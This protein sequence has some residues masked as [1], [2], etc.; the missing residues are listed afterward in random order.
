[1]HYSYLKDVSKMAFIYKSF[2]FNT[3]KNMIYLGK[4]MI[5]LGVYSV[6]LKK[7]L[8]LFLGKIYP[9]TE[10]KF[11]FQPAK[12]IGS[13]F[14][15]KDRAPSHVRSSVVYKFSCSSCKATYYGKTSRHFIVRCREHLGVN[16]KG[17]CIKGLVHQRPYC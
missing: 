9:H 2:E 3:T 13:F 10:F 6:R 4:N 5:Y 12:R 16:K 15:F 1:M 11:V 14:P 7:N 17:K 8:N